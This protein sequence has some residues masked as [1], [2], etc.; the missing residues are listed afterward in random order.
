MRRRGI[1]D[2]SLL[3][4]RLSQCWHVLSDEANFEGCHLTLKL[5]P[6]GIQSGQTRSNPRYFRLDV[7]LFCHSEFPPNPFPSAKHSARNGMA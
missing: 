1:R 6:F 3:E 2:G 4:G 7:A 5:L